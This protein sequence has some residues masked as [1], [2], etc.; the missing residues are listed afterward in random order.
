MSSTIRIWTVKLT[1]QIYEEPIG[2]AS[3]RS[4]GGRFTISGDALEARS[5]ERGSSAPSA[6]DR[7]KPVHPTRIRRAVCFRLSTS[8]VR[9]D[10]LRLESNMFAWFPRD[11]SSRIPPIRTSGL[12]RQR[13]ALVSRA[14]EKHPQSAGDAGSPF[15]GCH[16]ECANV[17]QLVGGDPERS[18][19]SSGSRSRSGRRHC[20]LHPRHHG[21]AWPSEKVLGDSQTFG[22]FH[23]DSR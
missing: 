7:A 1:P 17:H 20:P 4:L 12:G 22:K 19:V 8:V 23:R 10:P 3:A 21:H 16:S 18:E 14:L 6:A 5:L 2:D 9:A 11:R 15:P 13:A